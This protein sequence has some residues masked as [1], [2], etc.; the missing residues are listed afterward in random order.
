MEILCRDGMGSL[1]SAY[2]KKFNMFGD[3]NDDCGLLSA[4]SPEQVWRRKYRLWGEPEKSTK[5]NGTFT[6]NRYN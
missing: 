3:V 1:Y 6:M 5:A 4:C 2:A